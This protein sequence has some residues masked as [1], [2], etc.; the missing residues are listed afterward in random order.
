MGLDVFRGACGAFPPS[1][2]PLL[3]QRHVAPRLGLLRTVRGPGFATRS[4]RCVVG[5]PLY[6]ATASLRSCACR[7]RGDAPAPRGLCGPGEAAL[8]DSAPFDRPP[9]SP[10]SHFGR[11]LAGRPRRHPPRVPSA[12][13]QVPIATSGSSAA[14]CRSSSCVGDVFG[15]SLP[16]AVRRT[17]SGRKRIGFFGR[18]VTVVFLHL[19]R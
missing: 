13:H 3:L 18:F 6:P 9:V 1:V 2:F 8:F 17:S 12:A 19:S 7:T 11:R 4:L 15:G 5:R 10:L 16:P 14:F